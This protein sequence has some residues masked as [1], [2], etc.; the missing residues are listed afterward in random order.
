ML[1]KQEYHVLLPIFKKKLRQL[2][3]LPHLL[4]QK[5]YRQLTGRLMDY[6]YQWKG[7]S[8]VSFFPFLSLLSGLWALYDLLYQ[9]IFSSPLLKPLSQHKLQAQHPSAI[10]AVAIAKEIGLVAGGIAAAVL[11]LSPLDFMLL[12]PLPLMTSPMVPSPLLMTLAFYNKLTTHETW[13]KDANHILHG[14][15]QHP[16]I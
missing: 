1:G 2:M 11:N 8:F 12:L 10:N 7:S 6:A 5:S 4:T 13:R 3:G 14:W 16:Q 15:V 9:I